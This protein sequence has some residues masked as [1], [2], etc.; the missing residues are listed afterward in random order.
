LFKRG[1]RKVRVSEGKTWAVL[2][3][4]TALARRDISGGGGTVEMGGGEVCCGP[5]KTRE[6]K[7]DRGIE[8]ILGALLSQYTKAG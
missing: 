2:G 7:A 3:F 6:Q 4:F 1:R 5:L 8:E